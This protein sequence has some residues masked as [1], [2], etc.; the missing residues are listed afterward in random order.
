MC[1]LTTTQTAALL[2]FVPLAVEQKLFN[3]KLYATIFA[4]RLGEDV[5]TWQVLVNLTVKLNLTL[6]AILSVKDGWNITKGT[7]NPPDVNELVVFKAVPLV[8]YQ[9][10]FQY[11]QPARTMC[12]IVVVL[13]RIVV[14]AFLAGKA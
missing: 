8:S 13:H 11:R 4:G 5:T 6:K 14:E 9:S 7:E 1:R 10:L 3:L 12:Y 2:L